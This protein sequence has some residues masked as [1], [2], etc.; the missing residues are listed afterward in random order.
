MSFMAT[1]DSSAV[2]S[3]RKA[4]YLIVGTLTILTEIDGCCATGPIGK[5]SF[6]RSRFLAASVSRTP[7]TAEVCC[8]EPES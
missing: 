2:C 6:P 7:N 1:S 4:S 8:S 5:S 3:L